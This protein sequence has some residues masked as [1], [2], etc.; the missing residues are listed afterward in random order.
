MNCIGEYY[1][2]LWC[3]WSSCSNVGYLSQTR[4]GLWRVATL[5]LRRFTSEGIFCK[6]EGHFILFLLWHPTV[7][8]IL[9]HYAVELAHFAPL[10]SAVYMPQ[11]CPPSCDRH[12]RIGLCFWPICSSRLGSI[13]CSNKNTTL[14]QSESSGLTLH[15]STIVSCC[16]QERRLPVAWMWA[17]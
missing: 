4:V 2:G 10:V 7:Q 12:S 14:Y 9:C 6:N 16:R 1:L 11:Q 15:S 5:L 13:P 3:T 8:D 17:Q